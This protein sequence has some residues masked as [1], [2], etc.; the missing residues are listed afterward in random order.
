MSEDGKT[1]VRDQVSGPEV[2]PQIT[3]VKRGP[4]GFTGQAQIGADEL[5]EFYEGNVEEMR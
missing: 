3:P 4:E 5:V 2:N 1:G